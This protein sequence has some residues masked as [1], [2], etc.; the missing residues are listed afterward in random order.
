MMREE[1][2]ILKDSIDEKISK[3]RYVP[4]KKEEKK[5]SFEKLSVITAAVLAVS[6]LVGLIMTLMRLF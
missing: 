5:S 3:A 4:K 1:K 2:D 6:V